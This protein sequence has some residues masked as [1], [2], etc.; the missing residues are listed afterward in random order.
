MPR[1]ALDCKD[2]RFLLIAL[3]AAA[4][5]VGAAWMGRDLPRGGPGKLGLAIA[6]AGATT[7][8]VLMIVRGIRRLD[9]LQRRIQ[10]EALAG[11]FAGTAILVTTWGFLEIAGAPEIRWGLWI[12]P[13]MTV[14]WA[15]GL[16]LARRR[17]R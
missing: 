3:A 16:L 7:V 12:W 15:G 5:I 10:L 1:R 17:Y 9:E 2:P 14:L 11:A 13:A 8:V 6:Q 4:V